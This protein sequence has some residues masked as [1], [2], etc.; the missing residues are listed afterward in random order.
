MASNWTEEQQAAIDA[1]GNSIIVS[2]AAGSGKTSVL[3]ERL[4]RQLSDAENKVSAEKIIVV[5]FTNDAAA[6]MKNRLIIGLSRMIDEE[7]DNRWLYEQ[8]AMLQYAKICTIHSFCFDLIRENIQELDIS[9][10][11]RIMEENEQKIVINSSIENI[12]ERAYKESPDD[13]DKLYNYFCNKNDDN[14][15]KVITQVYESLENVPFSNFWLD[16][17]TNLYE[18]SELSEN[19][20]LKKYVEYLSGEC[21]SILQDIKALLTISYGLGDKRIC[22]LL[23][24]E[25]EMIE[26]VL[27]QCR[28]EN[29][30]IKDLITVIDYVKFTSF[31]RKTKSSIMLDER[32]NLMEE[33]KTYRDKLTKL[34]NKSKEIFLYAANDLKAH[35]EIIRILRYLIGELKTEVWSMKV[36][37]NA[38]GFNDAEQLTL[39]LLSDVDSDGNIKKSKIAEEVSEFYEIIML[40][41]FQDSNNNQD[42]I[43]KLLSRNG[44]AERNGDNVFLVGDIKQSIYRFRMANPKIFIET[45]NKSVP[46]NEKNMDGMSYIKL[47]RNFRSSTGVVDFVN[48]IFE[49]IMS[50]A[51]GEIDYDDSERL[52]QGAKYPEDV[53]NSTQIALIKKDKDDKTNYEAFYVAEQISK[54]I[55]EKYPVCNKGGAS[56]RPC[57]MRDFCILI[58]NKK[59]AIEYVNALE[60]YGISAYAEETEGY[61]KSREVSVLLNFLRI[62]DNPLLDT[63]LTSVMLSQMFMMSADDVAKIRLVNREA[64]MFSALCEG[65]GKKY[66]VDNAEHNEP[67]FSGDLLAK[68]NYLYNTINEMRMY[69]I[70]YT[71]EELIRKIYD[72]TD[73]LSVM[74]L[75]RDSEKRKANLRILLEYAKSYEQSMSGTTYGGVSGFLRYIDNIQRLGS[76]FNRAPTISPT[77]NVVQIKTIHKSKGLEFPFVFLVGTN[78]EFSSEDSKKAVQFSYENGFGFKLQN[79]I[80]LTKYT[81][82]PYEAISN[83][84]KLN[85]ISEEMRLLYVALTRA[86]DRLFLS[87]EITETQIKK[88]KMYARSIIANGEISEMIAKSANSMSDWLLM[89]LTAHNNSDLLRSLA[90]IDDCLTLGSNCNI[91]FINYEYCD[92]KKQESQKQKNITA[93]SKIIDKIR[94][95]IDFEYNLFESELIAKLSVSEVSKLDEE[96]ELTLKRPKLISESTKLTPTEKGTALHN[97]LQYADFKKAQSNADL[98]IERL[99]SMAYLTRK[100]GDAINKEMLNN[101]F[102]SD[103]YKRIENAKIVTREKSFMIKISELN[104]SSNFGDKYKNTDGMLHGIIDLIIEEDDGLVLV[105]YK[106]D[107]VNSPQELINRYSKQLELYKESLEAIT[108]KRVK[109]TYIYSFKLGCTIN[110]F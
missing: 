88:I 107:Y 66:D 90:D 87:F 78:T 21:K 42:L 22:D 94:K 5:T 110:V 28:K 26:V 29:I 58:R 69:S 45:M 79:K 25:I 47:N 73:F 3:V 106:T 16:R 56:T 35:G 53:I 1:R 18:T 74:Q 20:Y 102:K 48:Y 52:I 91:D 44:T 62:I 103:L 12:L 93:N 27:N 63:A 92:N 68:A 10:G 84:N 43:F 96:I 70:S 86:R 65:I 9:S 81:T 89:C 31:P 49:N 39:K 72:S 100:Q 77:E 57:E 59:K 75:Y 51:V 19:I 61:L 99:I 41:E 55:K 14:L 6:E 32:E 80:E 7:P 13:M 104:L 109:N 95:N 2:A 30:I 17:I 36:K 67:I 24:K 33:R 34:L 98:E 11:F 82:L 46:Y 8:Q 37:K 64:S 85:L 108:K 23:N 54:M 38:I 76:D 105:D 50:Q 40:D 97:F 15:I 101:F 4:L 83:I 60:R 71:L